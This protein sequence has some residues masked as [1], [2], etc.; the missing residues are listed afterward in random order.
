MNQK[1][2]ENEDKIFKA[3]QDLKD[4]MFGMKQPYI[5]YCYDHTDEDG[6]VFN[7]EKA[8]VFVEN[9]CEF[10]TKT[11]T[12][13]GELIPVMPLFFR[14][15]VMLLAAIC[16]SGDWVFVSFRKLAKAALK[17]SPEEEST[18]DR[19]VESHRSQINRM[20]S[21]NI[22]WPDYELLRACLGQV[23]A[24]DFYLCVKHTLEAF[25]DDRRLNVL[26]RDQLTESVVARISRL[27]ATVERDLKRAEDPWEDEQ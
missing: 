3:I 25:V 16:N 13:R 7:K 24:E 12:Y 15:T 27:S 5:R 11:R 17:S 6:L 14:V 2:A 22:F 8:E 21:A 9:L 1:Q 10:S 26:D 18:Y 20:F 19:I 4:S 23:D